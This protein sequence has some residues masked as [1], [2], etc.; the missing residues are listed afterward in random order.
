MQIL[1]YRAVCPFVSVQKCLEC[2]VTNRNKTSDCPL[3]QPKYKRAII[4]AVGM[5]SHFCLQ[6]L[7][8]VGV[9]KES[10]LTLSGPTVFLAQPSEVLSG[11]DFESK[12]SKSVKLG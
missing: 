8:Q 6:S 2:A 9:E 5:S 12:V 11:F 3:G 7:C 4:K 10:C 1:S